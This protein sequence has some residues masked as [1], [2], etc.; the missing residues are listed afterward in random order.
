MVFSDALKGSV[1]AYNFE[2]NQL[3]TTVRTKTAAKGDDSSSIASKSL[4]KTM[5]EPDM[6]D[7]GYPLL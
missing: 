2:G 7:S 6:S 3:L 5:F 4:G 1:E